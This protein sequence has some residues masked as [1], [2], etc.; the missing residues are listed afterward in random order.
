[1][2]LDHFRGRHGSAPDLFNAV[3]ITAVQQ[4]LVGDWHKLLPRLG[5]AGLAFQLVPADAVLLALPL[6][7]LFPSFLGLEIFMLAIDC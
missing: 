3:A 2:A 7:A 1:M 5:V 6:A 4:V